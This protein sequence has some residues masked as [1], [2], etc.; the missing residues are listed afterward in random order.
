LEL[1][2]ITREIIHSVEEKSGIPVRVTQDNNLS[3]IAAVRMARKGAS[4]VHLVLY[5]SYPGESPD[6][7]ISFECGYILRLFSNP[8]EKRLE[9]TDT[10]QGK[11]EVERLIKAPGGVAEKFR[12]KRSQVEELRVQFLS[13]LIIHLR[14]VPVGLRVSEWL[15]VNYPELE[16]L[17]KEQVLKELELNQQSLKAEIR[18]ITPPKIYRA[19]QAISGAYALYWSEFY[20]KPEMFNPFI[21]QGFDRDA[22]SLLEIYHQLPEGPDNDQALIDAWGSKLGLSDWYA[23]RPYQA[24]V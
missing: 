7:Q 19:T 17:E 22:R 3:T 13:G 8:P 10:V 16:A 2:Q 23:W 15:A 6:Y 9:I 12:L 4:P 21:Q 1:R 18:E 11:E 20:G 5:K 24:P 14:S